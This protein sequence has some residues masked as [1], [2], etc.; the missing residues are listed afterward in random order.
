MRDITAS[1][2]GRIVEK[3]GSGFKAAI[4]RASIRIA[5]INV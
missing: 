4:A 1:I 2:F 5:G 3:S